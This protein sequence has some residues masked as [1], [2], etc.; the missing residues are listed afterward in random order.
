MQYSF[1][2]ASTISV[3]LLITTLVSQ[4]RKGTGFGTAVRQPLSVIF[5]I[6]FVVFLGLFLKNAQNAVQS[7]TSAIGVQNGSSGTAPSTAVLPGNI[8]LAR[9][10]SLTNY[11]YTEVTHGGGR[12]MTISGNVYSAD[13]W[14][15]TTPWVERYIG[16]HTYVKLGKWYASQGRS[17]P[18]LLGFAQQFWGMATNPTVRLRED[19]TCNFANTAGHVWTVVRANGG[20]ETIVPMSACIADQS[21]ALLQLLAGLSNAISGN[22][23]IGASFT[24]TAIGTVQPFAVPSPVVGG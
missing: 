8:S 7:G 10:E 11:S 24:I 1:L 12:S 3:V 4:M 20:A 2:A 18:P 23:N 14:E 16:T 21:G 5:G 22:K 6:L 15:T 17:T 9:L 13:N 19:G